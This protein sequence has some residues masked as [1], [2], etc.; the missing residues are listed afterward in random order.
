[1]AT[2]YKL[3]EFYRA[4]VERAEEEDE[5]RS[6]EKANTRSLEDLR[7]RYRKAFLQKGKGGKGACKNC[8][9]NTRS[10]VFYKSR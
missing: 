4:E 9:A 1:M 8:G 2:V 5:I 6:E 10:I 3:Q 7:K